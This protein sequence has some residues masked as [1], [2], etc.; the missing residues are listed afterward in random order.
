LGC[1]HH[2]FPEVGEVSPE[3]LGSR[4]RGAGIAVMRITSHQRGCAAAWHGMERIQC[5]T[6]VP[7]R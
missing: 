4:T 1:S 6:Q 5:T 3:H 2:D 7:A